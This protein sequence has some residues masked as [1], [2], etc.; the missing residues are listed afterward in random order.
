MKKL[1]KKLFVFASFSLLI[2]SFLFIGCKKDDQ[3]NDDPSLKLVFSSE[4]ILFDTVFSTVGSTTRKFY[5]KNPT[6]D[7]IVISSIHLANGTAS[8]YSMNV[9]G[10][11]TQNIDN[12][13][14]A[15]DDSIFIFVKVTVD[16][17]NSNSPMVVRDSIIF[18]FNGNMQDIDLTAWGQDAHYI[19]ANKTIGGSLH[20]KIV[21]GENENITW[22]NDKPYLVYGYAVVDSTGHLN[23]DPGC[24]IHFYNNSGMWIYKGGSFNVNGTLDEPVTFQGS[25][26]EAGYKDLPGQWDRIW[27]NEGTNDNVI[28]YA[29]IKNGF[30]GIQ[31]ETMSASMGNRLKITNTVI[32]NMTG[33]GLLSRYYKIIGGN[34]VF[35]NCGGYAMALTTGG[36]YDFRHCTLGNYY[37]Y[38]SRQTPSLLIT[39]Y[40]EDLSTGTIFAG[41][42][43]SAYFGNC[44]IFGS[45]A[46]ELAL[47]STSGATFH[48]K[49]E[50]CLLK[51]SV[52]T[53]TVYFTDCIFNQDALFMNYNNNDYSLMPGSA[54]IDAG[55][56]NII[57][58]SILDLAKDLKGNNR[59]LNPPPDL[60]AYDYEP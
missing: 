41:D 38:S 47:D 53:G 13:E 45:N 20:Y 29:I 8:Q 57:Y 19:V 26:L 24:R 16:P 14:I 37:S 40:Y 34:C 11:P 58:S 30:I 59:T 3:I 21:A 10:T 50:N 54:A 31:A 27:I 2:F 28:N 39:N 32:K 33:I 43:D 1:M 52:N 36:S 5:V 35:A 55:N 51:S 12:V 17:Q 44:I 56:I 48:Y 42:L 7:N 23:I 46:E 22:P 9:D 6:N 60:G 4:S 18:E 25:R 49:F 15:P